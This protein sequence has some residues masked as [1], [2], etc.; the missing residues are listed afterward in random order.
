MINQIHFAN[1][2]DAKL[3][4]DYVKQKRLKL[5]NREGVLNQLFGI[6]N[7]VQLMCSRKSHYSEP[8][9]LLDF[10][11]QFIKSKQNSKQNVLILEGKSGAGKSLFLLE[12]LRQ[13]NRLYN[14]G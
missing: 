7:Y 12:M 6:Q 8:T 14:N 2:D 4:A 11:L 13:L 10:T 3:I 5:L 9:K 1:K